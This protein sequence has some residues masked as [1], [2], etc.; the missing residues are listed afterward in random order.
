[1]LYHS[2]KEGENTMAQTLAQ[3]PENTLSHFSPANTMTP[4]HQS[5]GLDIKDLKFLIQKL[6]FYKKKAEV[7]MKKKQDEEAL[8]GSQFAE[9]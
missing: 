3:S 9:K 7:A 5:A 4:S 8:M 1:M 6:E 2:I